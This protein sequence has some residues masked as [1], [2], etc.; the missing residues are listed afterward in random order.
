[1]KIIRLLNDNNPYI[2]LA[3]EEFLLKE[4]KDLL[5]EDLFLI[6]KNSNTIV[7]GNSQNAL[8]EI[9]LLYVNENNIKVSRRMTGGGAVYH[10]FG[11]IN[12]TFIKRKQRPMF[13]FKVCLSEIIEFL[14]SL[15]LNATY[16]G[17]N[18]ILIGDKKISGTAVHF[19]ENDYLIHGT[20]LYDVDIDILINCLNVNKEKLASK[21]I[22]SIKSRVDNIKNHLL[23][24][25]SVVEFENML[26][27]YFE[28]KYNEKVIYMDLKNDLRVLDLTLNK[29]AKYDYIFGK[30]YDFNFKNT[31]KLSASILTVNINIDSGFIKDI[32]FYTD[33][34]YD[35]KLNILETIFKNTKYTIQS[36]KTILESLEIN[37]YYQELNNDLFIKLLFNNN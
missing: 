5:D 24:K 21:G 1:M 37:Y 31:L 7:I 28:N 22:E 16:S 34:L 33:A 17:R 4:K 26:I 3:S 20:L 36:V 13:D 11:N 2:N 32:H 19:Y 35:S 27:S 12:F 8:S 6:W 15:N 14:N 25:P 30:N 29:Y 9:N 18:D 23:S 10:D